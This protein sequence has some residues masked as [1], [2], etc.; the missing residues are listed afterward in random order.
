MAEISPCPVC[1]STAGL[2][3]EPDKTWLCGFEGRGRL[4]R[5]ADCALIHLRDYGP[6]L[7]E[8]HGDDFIAA[9]VAQHARSPEHERLFA[10]R[11]A[12]AE[13]RTPGRRVLDIGVGNGAF[14][15]EAQRRGWHPH[16][17]DTSTVPRDLLAPHGIEVTVGE[18]L[19]FLQAHPAAFDLIHLNHTL[20]HIPRAAETIVAARRALAPGGLLYVEVPNEFENWLFRAA[21]ALGRKR[22]AGSLLGRSRPLR[23]PSPHLYFFN[24]R[25]LRKLATRAGF[26]SFDVHAR[27]REP[28]E[29]DAGEVAAAAAAVLDGGL[30][31]TLTASAA[32]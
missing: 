30:F 11:L 9:K 21:D 7:L 16:G 12:W 29:L 28:L 2:L 20:E 10:E 3:P 6:E 17:V 31:L 5:C 4:V 32:A 18:G 26:D 1:L 15:L 8:S 19:D 13:S 23:E 25:S 22:K 27:R 24:K 14:L